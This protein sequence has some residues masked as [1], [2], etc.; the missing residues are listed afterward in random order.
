MGAIRGRLV[1]GGGRVAAAGLVVSLLVCFGSLPRQPAR[2][3]QDLVLESSTSG[4]FSIRGHVVGLFPGE[5][6]DLWLTL[7]NRNNFAINVTSVTV[8]AGDANPVCTSYYLVPARFSGSLRVRANSY[9]RLKLTV[10][11]RKRAPDPCQDARFP[12][13]YRGRATRA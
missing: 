1:V 4:R 11:L 2:L 7:V 8:R 12:L 3:G 9:R 5:R 10:V 6:G 13:S